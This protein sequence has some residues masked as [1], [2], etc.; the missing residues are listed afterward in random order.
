[1]DT[2]VCLKAQK[3]AKESNT[4]GMKSILSFW[5]PP[6]PK[7]ASIATTSATPALIPTQGIAEKTIRLPDDAPQDPS[8]PP[9]ATALSK[10]APDPPTRELDSDGGLMYA[11]ALE[12]LRY[13]L[14]QLCKPELTR[15][16][17]FL[18]MFESP[19]AAFDNDP[20]LSAEDIWEQSLNSEL[21]RAFGSWGDGLKEEDAAG[22]TVERVAGFVRFV[23]YFVK[24]GINAALFKERARQLVKGLEKW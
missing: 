11:A 8:H 6:K 1:M 12:T 20:N 21:H 10:S 17:D 2:K 14:P 24:R 18:K 4:A 15:S 13:Y 3:K 7:A 9:E 22:L 5:G 19:P 23:E 16:N